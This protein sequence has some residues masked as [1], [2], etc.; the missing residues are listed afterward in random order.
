MM[1]LDDVFL[2]ND[3]VQ[4]R[5]L[6]IVASETPWRNYI[7]I[8]KPEFREDNISVEMQAVELIMRD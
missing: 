3:V 1:F 4:F 2:Q 7:L 5:G 6:Y 8:C